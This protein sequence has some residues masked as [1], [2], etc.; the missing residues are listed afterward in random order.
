MTDRPI[1]FSAP[2]VRVLLDGSLAERDSEYVRCAT[3]D[4]AGA[5]ELRCSDREPKKLRYTLGR[6]YLDQG[7]NRRAIANQAVDRLQLLANPKLTSAEDISSNCSA[8]FDI[9][10]SGSP[11]PKTAIC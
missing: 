9:H 7:T 4:D 1:I 10:L 3:H 8:S 5:V 11:S 6:S 2:I